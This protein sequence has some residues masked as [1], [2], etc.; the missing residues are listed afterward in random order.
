MPKLMQR[1]DR[2]E[3]ALR[4]L[5]G[6][7][8]CRLCYGHP[9]AAIRVMYEPDPHGPGFRKTGECCL[10]MD[11]ANRITDDLRCR[12]C[13]A[14]AVQ[15]HLMDIVGSRSKPEGRRLSAA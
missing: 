8:T 3:R 2:L 11:D 5:D 13:G 9:V 12:E 6:A 10:A 7:G 1:L 14:E 15:V 4:T